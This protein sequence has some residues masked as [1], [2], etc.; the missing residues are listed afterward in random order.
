M[1]QR[2][3]YEFVFQVSTEKTLTLNFHKCNVVCLVRL[4]L[5]PPVFLCMCLCIIKRIYLCVYVS[6]NVCNIV[7]LSLF[8]WSRFT[9]ILEAV[10]K[11]IRRTKPISYSFSAQQYKVSM[12][13]PRSYW[14]EN[15][16]IKT[17]ES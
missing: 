17:L 3:S 10:G 14:L 9:E 1:R 11:K 16:N 8:A 4:Y 12:I 7:I 2:E 13:V 15:D 5:Y 6:L